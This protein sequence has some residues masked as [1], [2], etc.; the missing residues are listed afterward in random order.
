LLGPAEHAVDVAPSLV[1]ASLR[2]I[3]THGIRLLPTYLEELHGGRAKRRPVFTT[4]GSLPAITVLDADDAL[5]IVA[6]A[7]AMRLAIAPHRPPATLRSRW[8]VTWSAHPCAVARSRGSRLL[9][10]YLPMIPRAQLR[11][12]GTRAIP[13]S[14]LMQHRKHQVAP[15]AAGSAMTHTARRAARAGMARRSAGESERTRS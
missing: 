6:G 9:A 4:V 3:D 13:G 8:R 1:D 2:G 10:N 14:Q 7:A 12:E 11:R 5:G 15:G